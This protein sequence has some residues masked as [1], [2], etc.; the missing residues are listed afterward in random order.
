MLFQIAT[1]CIGIIAGLLIG[2]VGIGGV[3]VVPALLVLPL[4]VNCFAK[5]WF[6]ETEP[7]LEDMPVEVAICTAMS[8]YIIAGFVGVVSYELQNPFFFKPKQ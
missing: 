8:S 3:I 6:N 7:V 4:F 2:C 5:N 1:A